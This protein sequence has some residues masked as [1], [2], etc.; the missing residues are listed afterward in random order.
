MAVD[1]DNARMVVLDVVERCADL[2]EVFTA[3]VMAA[4]QR[5]RFEGPTVPPPGHPFRADFESWAESAGCGDG[6]RGFPAPRFPGPDGR[7]VGLWTVAQGKWVDSP[8][9]KRWAGEAVTF[10]DWY[11]E[12]REAA[13]RTADLLGRLVELRR[14]VADPPKDD[15][16]SDGWVPPDF[17]ALEQHE[18]AILAGEDPETGLPAEVAAWLSKLVHEPKR[19]YAAAYCAHRLYGDPAPADPGTD[20][21]GKARKRADHVLRAVVS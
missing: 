19:V 16:L 6:R 18:A 2:E 15:E 8:T 17:V 10:E 14:F 12:D 21:A 4:T 9:G 20:W 7:W 3:E 11:Q 1:L 5:W 13:D